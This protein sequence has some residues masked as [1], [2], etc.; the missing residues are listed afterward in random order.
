MSKSA[1][2]RRASAAFRMDHMGSRFPDLKKRVATA[3]LDLAASIIEMDEAIERE[4]AEIASGANPRH[5]SLFE[6]A[7]VEMSKTVH[8]QAL[9]DLLRGDDSV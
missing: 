9:A 1:E 2:E 4:E 7:T 3:A 8:A 5:H 6:R